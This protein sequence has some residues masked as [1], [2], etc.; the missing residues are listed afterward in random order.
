MIN[1]SIDPFNK[2]LNALF[3]ALDVKFILFNFI[4][5]IQKLKTMKA[6]Q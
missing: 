2:S 6:I 3:S 1:P 4:Q 5:N